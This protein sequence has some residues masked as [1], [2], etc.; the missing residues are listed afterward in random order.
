MSAHYLVKRD[1]T[2]LQLVRDDDIAYHAGNWDYNQESIGI[3]HER[4]S[5]GELTTAQYQASAQLVQWLTGQYAADVV[6]PAGIAP[7]SP[8]SGLGIIGHVQ[9]PDPNNPS[10]GGGANHHT[11]PTNWDW[12]YYKSL[13]GIDNTPPSI[14]S[15]S[16][17]PD[18]V[19]QG[20]SITLTANSVTDNDGTVAKVEFYRDTNGNGA[21][22][23]GT[24]TLLWTDTSS[25][26]GWTC[27]VS[28]SGFPVGSNR[29]MT[30][31][32]GR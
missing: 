14:G 22:D 29:Y 32:A 18:P 4:Y 2:V 27:T 8:T 26:G 10:L 31:S 16:V 19:M 3:E 20:N 21:I 6:F 1:G 24:D 15:L 13:F 11:D 9:V 17:N 7:P 23:V 28:T 30:R 5:G 12:N 25:S